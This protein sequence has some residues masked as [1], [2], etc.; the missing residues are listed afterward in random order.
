MT[1]QGEK[2]KDWIYNFYPGAK[3]G[4]VIVNPFPSG[5]AGIA[6]ASYIVCAS[7]EDD[8]CLGRKETAL[9]RMNSEASYVVTRDYKVKYKYQINGKIKPA[10]IIVPAG[11]LTDLA[12]VPKWARSFYGRVGKHLE[13][14]IV[15]DWLYMA[16]QLFK[17]YNKKPYKKPPCHYRDFADNLFYHLLIASKGFCVC[18]AALMTCA[19]K[20]RGEKAFLERDDGFIIIKKKKDVLA[21]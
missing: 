20:K 3:K 6:S 10:S 14:A 12:S 11:M 15:H 1:M 18:E 9:K 8:L 17:P 21:C 19:V 2:G 13:A 5:G 7:Y 16:W 4:D